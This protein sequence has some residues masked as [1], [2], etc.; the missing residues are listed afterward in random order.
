MS[1]VRQQLL[2]YVQVAII[3]QTIQTIRTPNNYEIVKISCLCDAHTITWVELLPKTMRNIFWMW[4]HDAPCQ[5]YVCSGTTG[6]SCLACDKTCSTVQD[7]TRL[8]V[9]V[10]LRRFFWTLQILYLK[11]ET[12]S[13]FS[14]PKLAGTRIFSQL[15][16]LAMCNRMAATSSVGLWTNGSYEAIDTC[17]SS[18]S[19]NVNTQ[20]LLIPV[21]EIRGTTWD[22][23]KLKI[24]MKAVN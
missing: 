2:F 21:A 15:P 17:L 24:E 10:T 7:E 20:V 3:V 9:A 5:V 4:L 18:N 16:R 6:R 23:Q 12:W 11:Y 8:N 14:D 13:Q 19:I 1:V 22:L